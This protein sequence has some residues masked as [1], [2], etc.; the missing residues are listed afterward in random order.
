MMTERVVAPGVLARKYTTDGYAI[1]TMTIDNQVADITYLRDILDWYEEPV[2]GTPEPE[3]VD[4][5]YRAAVDPKVHE[6]C[7]NL[8]Q[9]VGSQFVF[10]LCTSQVFFQL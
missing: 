6:A 10:G 4:R 1:A 5:L 7:K 8:E 2:K 9:P 3:V